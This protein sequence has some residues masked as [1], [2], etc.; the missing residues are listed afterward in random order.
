MFQLTL[1]F[2][3]SAPTGSVGEIAT[4]D[5]RQVD[6]IQR[7]RITD[8]VD[9]FLTGDEVDVGQGQNGVQEVKESLLAMRSVEEPGCVEKQGKWGLGF[10]VMFQE[11]LG[12]DLLDGSGIFFVKTSISH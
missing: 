7:L 3:P 6:G 5:R 11:V 12:E 2:P 9:Q 10:G 4:Q 8:P 1:V